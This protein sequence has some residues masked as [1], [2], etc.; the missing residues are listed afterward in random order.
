MIIFVEL[1]YLSRMLVRVRIGE[2]QGNCA[3]LCRGCEGRGVRTANG[4]AQHAPFYLA[5]S[6]YNVDLRNSIPTQIRQLVLD[7]RNSRG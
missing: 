5:E 7:I 6:V 2:Q 4:D 1:E 3:P